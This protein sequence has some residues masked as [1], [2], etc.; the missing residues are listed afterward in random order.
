MDSGPQSRDVIDEIIRWAAAREAVRAVL[1]TSTRAVPGAPVDVLSDYDVILIVHDIAPFVAER[2][3]LSDFGE[4]LAVYW[5]PVHPN[6][7]F[8]IEQC[9]NVTQYDDGLKIDF[10]LWPVAL[11]ERIAAAAELPA[12]LDAGYRV[13]LDKDGLA[14]G[15]RPPSGEAYRPKPPDRAAY[16]THVND[17]LSDAPYVAKCLLRGELFP[18]KWALDYDMKHVYLR[19]L[20]EW[21][22]G[23]A[24]DWSLPVGALGKGLQ[25]RLPAELWAELERCYADAE[26]EGNWEALARTLALFRRVALEVG[27]ALGYEYP[28]ER[29]ERV[30]AYVERMRRL[31]RPAGTADERGWPIGP[32]RVACGSRAHPPGWILLMLAAGGTPPAPQP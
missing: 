30:S 18:L 7:Q 3:W 29:H 11:L 5:D 28:H 20:L 16:E 23:V 25:K 9:A 31:E 26:P 17:F 15:L 21:R 6:P 14:A 22:V 13:L 1:L 27:A 8:G 4:V 10:T 19:P 32:S 2:G 12:E 24:T